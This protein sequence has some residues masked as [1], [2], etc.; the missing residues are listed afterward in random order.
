VRGAPEPSIPRPLI[1]AVDS[2]ADALR[3]VEREL[4]T[5]YEADYR[6]ACERSTEGALGRLGE[7]GAAEDVALVMAALRMEGTSGVEFLSRVREVRPLAKRVL[8]IEPRDTETREILPRAMA[9]GRIDDYEF[10]PG[11][12]PNEHFHQAVTDLLEEWT[13]PYRSEI[14]ALARVV[15]ERGSRRV[16]EAMELF[17]RYGVPC[18]FYPQD[19][20]EGRT[21]LEQVGRGA[22]RLPVIVLDGG[23]ALVD[24]SNREVAD[25]FVGADA[26]P[27]RQGCDLVV[28]GGGPAGLAA[29]VYG[30]SE[31]LEVW[32]VEREAI[33]GQAGASSLIRN[34]LGFPRGVSGQKLTYRAFQQAQLFG[35]DFRLM[36]QAAGLRREGGELVVALSDGKELAGRAVIVATGASYRQL[37][38]PSLEA[39]N[40]AGVFY[41]AATT[42]AQALKGR[43]AYVVGGAN[44]AGQAAMHV[45]KYASMVTLVVRGSSLEAG[46]SDYLVQQILATPNIHARLHHEVIDGH[47]RLRLEGLTLRDRDTGA[48]Q[49]V[50]AS[51]LFVLIGAEPRTDWL[52]GAVERD[53]SGYVLTGRDLGAWPLERGPLPL[54]TS[55]PGVFAAGDVR[56][57]SVKRV[58]SAVGEGAIAVQLVHEY[59]ADPSSP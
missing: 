18:S 47:G 25:A 50:D 12:P 30:A 55:L 45:S 58:S 2:D 32:V 8:L 15:G 36:R 3:R 43:E 10:K 7:L 49:E 39:L 59:L 31:G 42:E 20:E 54:E 38:V 41:G 6:V 19:S 24:P 46:M 1:L 9:L 17:D 23:R 21:L 27:G 40:G 34:Y 11:P 22:E 28:I 56:Y 48:T 51:A 53:H 13:R 44:S 37:G 33:G 52:H 26:Y 35:A 14:H 57:R 5:R 16:H 4:R 29:A